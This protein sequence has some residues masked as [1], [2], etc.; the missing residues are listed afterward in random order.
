MLAVSINDEAWE[1][2]SS[3]IMAKLALSQFP[4]MT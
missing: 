3:E 1:I 4:Q 2:E